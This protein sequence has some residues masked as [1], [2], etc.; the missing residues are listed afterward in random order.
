ML[1]KYILTLVFAPL[2]VWSSASY[3]A[4]VQID[5]L[6][7]VIHTSGGIT[8]G[9][10]GDLT[11]SG[12]FNLT[13]SGNF[14][15][16]QDIDVLVTPAIANSTNIPL[17]LPTGASY[18]GFNFSDGL[19]CIAVV[20]VICPTDDIMGTYDGISFEMNRIFF[21]GF[22]DDYAYDIN[23]SGVVSAVP[24]P[25]AI[26]LFASGLFSLFLFKRNKK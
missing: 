23:I 7:S 1:K 18:D 4:I 13:Q 6:N 20:G 5:S 9:G 19:V 14:L 15:I 25:A 17:P 8:G 24:V 2:L 22:P 10:Y 26:W 16:F 3:S 12:S 21:S 11:V